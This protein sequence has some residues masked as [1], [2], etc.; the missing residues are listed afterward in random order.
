MIDPRAC[1]IVA[2]IGIN[3]NGDIDI[4][5]QLIDLAKSAG[6]DAVKF[7]KRTVDVVYT[8]Q[9]LSKE[10][11]SPFGTTNGDLKRA[12]EFGYEEYAEIDRY[13][14]DQGIDWFASPWDEQSVDF[15]S[16]FNT[17]YLKLA[18]ASVTDK[19]LLQH[20]CQAG[21]PLLIS[22]G[23]CDLPMID[24]IVNTIDAAGGEIAMLYHCTSTY[25]SEMNELNLLGIRTL[26]EAFPQIPIGYSGHE[27]GVA[28][29]VL[30]V[31]LG[32]QSVERHITLRRTMWGSDHAAS[33]EPQG[34][35]RLVRDIRDFEVAKGDGTIRFL[36]QEK[37]IADK[38]RRKHTI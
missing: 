21:K 38:L 16:Q 24:R 8:A 9:E 27:A 1:Y 2:E 22:T 36:E 13:C 37:P 25:P 4:A 29:S 20:C 35:R 7:Q 6:C 31:A 34:L 3:H 14:S 32:A 30:S 26:K 12:L 5:K 17:P 11:E 10:R 19:A 15:L 23:M 18:S 33:L 28:P